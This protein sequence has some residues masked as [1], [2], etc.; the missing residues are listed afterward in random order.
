MR[1]DTLHLCIGCHTTTA[2]I[3]RDQLVDLRPNVG[4]QRCHGPGREHVL[5]MQ[6]G[7][8]ERSISVT[9]SAAEEIALC[10][11]CHRLPS[12]D[13]DP[14]P[15]PDILQNI[16]FQPASLMQSKC[17]QQSEDLKCSTC[18]NPHQ[19]ASDNLEHYV[20][21]C[22]SCH[23]GSQKKSCP[24]SP[25]ADCIRCHMPAIDIHRGIKFHDHW[26]RVRA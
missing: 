6:T 17:F 19:H 4:C 20:Q 5:A 21:R 11:Q 26:I 7:S 16:R 10:G 1:G 15:S 22:M 18:H 25:R 2:E 24:V 3:Q 23:T 9:R 13:P 14:R 8:H 12:S